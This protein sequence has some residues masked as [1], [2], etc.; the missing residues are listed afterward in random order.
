[1]GEE[2]AVTGCHVGS[3][4]V[5]CTTRMVGK[6]MVGEAV[7]VCE[8]GGGMGKGNTWEISVPFSQF[9]FKPKTALKKRKSAKKKK[10]KIYHHT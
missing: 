1:M 10:K 8:C 4:I 9:C 2:D 3:W 5:T 7:C 6:L